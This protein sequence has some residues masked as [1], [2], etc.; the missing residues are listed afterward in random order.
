MRAH[1][2]QWDGIR[3]LADELELKMHLAGMDLR[4]RWKLLQPR[5]RE[6]EN[7]LATSGKRA[8][9]AIDREVTA[10]SSA[11]ERLRDDLDSSDD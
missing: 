1:L 7:A 10:L 8:G 5:L 3:Q 6:L 2:S 9:A 4:D 11:L